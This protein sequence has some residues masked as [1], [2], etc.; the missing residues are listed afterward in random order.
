MQTLKVSLAERS[1]PIHI[2]AD[3]LSRGDLLLPHLK[4]KKVVVVTNVTV[5]PLYLN[6]LMETMADSGVLALPI[7]IPE[8]ER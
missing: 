8:G 3:I 1:Y 6:R 7:I 4:Q 2:G 5:A